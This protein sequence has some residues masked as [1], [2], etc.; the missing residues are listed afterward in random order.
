MARINLPRYKIRQFKVRAKRM[1]AAHKL[2]KVALAKRRAGQGWTRPKP[3]LL[4]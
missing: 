3:V 2:K 1:K 4:T